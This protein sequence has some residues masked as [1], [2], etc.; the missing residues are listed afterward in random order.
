VLSH[1]AKVFLFKK[2]IL[3]LSSFK[4]D[5]FQSQAVVVHTFNPST[6]EAEAGGSLNLSPTW[7]LD[8]VQDS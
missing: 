5:N 4:K 6:W 1:S 3:F 7:F 8:M 2:L